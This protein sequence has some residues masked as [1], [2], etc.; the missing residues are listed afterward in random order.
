MDTLVSV[1][2]CE[3]Y[4][5][6][7]VT[8]ALKEVL[9]PLGGLSWVTPG[10]HVAVKVNLVRRLAPEKAATT[11]PALVCAL[12]RMLI[13]RGAEVTVGDSP[14]GIF[15]PAYLKSVY[16]GTGMLAVEKTGARL[17]YDVSQTTA[18]FPDAKYAKT[19]D[20]T[21]WLAG[22]DAVISF[23]KLKTHGLMAM[24]GA[25]KNLFGIIPGTKKPE[26]HFLYPDTMKFAHMLV[27]LCEY[28]RPTLSIVDAVW[29]MEGNGPSS[30]DP[31]FIGCILASKNPYAC[32]LA[33]GR[34]M[35]VTEAPVLRAAYERGLAPERAEDLTFAGDLARFCQ[36]DFRLIPMRNVDL[37]LSRSGHLD[38]AFG[39][40]IRRKPKLRPELC[41]SC[42][43]CMRTCP[44]HAI[45][46]SPKPHFNRRTCICC[47]CCQEFCPE[48][49]IVVARS[50]FAK[51]LSR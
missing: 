21:G 9:K 17:N 1:A 5:N 34:I 13:A 46:L 10:M 28:I 20:Y 49:A 36:T 19:F 2:P 33:G 18:H 32:D 35:G 45:T 6:D 23:A 22:A 14:G 30:G 42:G 40:L 50:P 11:H 27:D 39:Y 7:V 38:R 43:V 29:G 37:F 44:A 15:M 41:I 24:T 31:R 4:E 47:F 12:C 48:S 51:F 26:F 25:V 16:T 8:H 3:N